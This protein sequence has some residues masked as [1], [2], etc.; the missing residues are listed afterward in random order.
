M[1]RKPKTQPN[2]EAAV[3]VPMPKLALPDKASAP[4]RRGRKPKAAAPSPA[5]LA[6]SSIDDLATDGV[7]ADATTAS[8]VKR[9]PGR[10]GPGR[11]PKTQPSPYDAA[12]VPLPETVA[13]DG[14][15]ASARRGRNAKA[16]TLSF[17]SPAAADVDGPVPDDAGADAS[18][19]GSTKAP[20]RRGPARKPK[21]AAGGK[22]AFLSPDTPVEP[23]SA[24]ADPSAAGSEPVRTAS[25]AHWDRATDAVR[26][27]WSEIERVAAQDGPDQGMARL[28]VAARVEGAGSRWPL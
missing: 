12:A 6:A 15:A 27:D 21:Q 10:R 22:A 20:G 18:K 1:A 23:A 16:A 4:T 3:A 5:S 19:A 17:A 11:R 24:E 8:P 14:T 2:T 25:A 26:F 7:E 9:A 13:A 28:L